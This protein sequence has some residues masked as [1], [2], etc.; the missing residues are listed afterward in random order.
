MGPITGLATIV[1]VL[2]VL[3][4]V[5]GLVVAGLTLGVVVPA[6]GRSRE[7]RRSKHLGVRAYYR[8]VLTH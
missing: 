7:D 2:T 1:T 3:E 5:L 8:P 6:L 4:V